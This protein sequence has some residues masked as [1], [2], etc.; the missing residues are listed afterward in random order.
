[1]FGSSSEHNTATESMKLVSV[2]VA[3]AVLLAGC[4]AG[5]GF[6]GS[7]TTDAS[8]GQPIATASSLTPMTSYDS[9]EDRGVASSE[10]EHPA[11]DD[12]DAKLPAPPTTSGRRAHA[13]LTVATRFAD[14]YLSYQIG[15]ET[16]AIRLAIDQTCTPAFARLLLS[17]P[18]SIPPARRSNPADRH[19]SLA[20]ATYTGPVSLGP[21]PPTQIVIARYRTTGRAAVSGQLTIE[22]NEGGTHWRVAGLE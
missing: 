16:N 7:G 11:A 5:P 15:R 4:A 17:Q 6:T 18:V 22:L 9:G 20:R 14:A 2:A 3:T 13:I 8:P 21:G 1:M 10:P 19:A 12:D